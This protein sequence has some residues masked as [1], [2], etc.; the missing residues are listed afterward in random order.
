MI[1]FFRKIRQ[2]LLSEGKNGK[3]LKYALGEILLVVIGILLALTINSWNEARV[4][5]NKIEEILIGIKNDL[6]HDI[7][8]FDKVINAFTKKDSIYKMVIK[9]SLHVED[10]QNH[11]EIAFVLAG[12]ADIKIENRALKMLT[13]NNAFYNSQNEPLC[14]K[15]TSFYSRFENELTVQL[16]EMGFYLNQNQTY[17]IHNMPWFADWAE[18]RTT[19][20]MISY[21]ADS[22]D[23]RNRIKMFQ[24]SEQIEIMHLKNFKK[25]ALE[26]IEAIDDR[27]R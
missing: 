7:E 14:L 4:E 8:I 22:W 19:P 11:P 17:W 3:Y 21:M 25:G 5:N 27:V 16:Q 9:R 18:G 1:K 26:I 20:D 2:T 24:L 10:Y 6:N 15:I 23:Y 12:F 13:N